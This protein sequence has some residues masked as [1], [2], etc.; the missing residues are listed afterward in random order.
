MK[1]K[2]LY[3]ALSYSIEEFYYSQ[4]SLRIMKIFPSSISF[5]DLLAIFPEISDSK[6]KLLTRFPVKLKQEQ[7]LLSESLTRKMQ[8]KT[9][10]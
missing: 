8:K 3:S 5:N 4:L 10:G 1:F 6:N 7:W 2:D 9:F